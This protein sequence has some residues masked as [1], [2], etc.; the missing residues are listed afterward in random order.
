MTALTAD[1]VAASVAARALP[2]A[3]PVDLDK[4]THG[5]ANR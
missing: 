4:G 3:R 2:F 5:T 1:A